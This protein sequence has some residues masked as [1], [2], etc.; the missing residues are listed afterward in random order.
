MRCF[1]L[2][3]VVVFVAC[4][5]PDPGLE[6]DPHPPLGDV[7]RTETERPDASLNPIDV[8]TP[9]DD[10]PA[11]ADAGATT[12]DGGPPPGKP[13]P[14]IPAL[15]IKVTAGLHFTEATVRKPLEDGL[16]YAVE[17]IAQNVDIG[18]KQS[19]P[20]TLV[21]ETSDNPYASGLANV[22][23][24][25]VW[26]PYG[27]PVTGTNQNYV[28]NISVH[29]L[30]H[31]LAHHLIAD[32]ALRPDTCV[33]EGLAS[34]IAGKYW[35]NAKSLPVTSLRAAARYEIEVGRATASMTTCNS[36]SDAWY[37]VYASYFEYLEKN[38]PGAILEV[39]SAKT[40]KSAYSGAWATW[41]Q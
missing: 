26:V 13:P 14:A 22:S 40:A 11:I 29:E 15:T 39:S 2:S 36:A 32:R 34:W 28:V 16:R 27:Y 17:R 25:T 18:T 38:V 5:A 8:A 30:G 37:K 35:M 12:K 4:S 1:L 6:L 33:N 3:F 10:A 21:F 31:L 7:D 20:L 19:P 23:T 41:M 24:A 9:A